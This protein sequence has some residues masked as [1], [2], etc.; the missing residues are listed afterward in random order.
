MGTAEF[1]VSVEKIQ[2]GIEYLESEFMVPLTKVGGQ[3]IDE[4]RELNNVLQ[5]DAINSLIQEQQSKLDELQADLTDIC[6]K[7]KS[8]MD[9]SSKV[10]GENQTNIDETLS[11]I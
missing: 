7:A 6:N 5:S 1:N 10:I 8:A 3:L 11:N 4:Y 2:Q 9:D